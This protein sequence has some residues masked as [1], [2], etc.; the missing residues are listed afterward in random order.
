SFG[1]YDEIDDDGICFRT[2][3]GTH[4]TKGSFFTRGTSRDENA[5][6]TENG[7]LYAE[8]MR[9]LLKK[10]E[11]TKQYVPAPELYQDENNNEVGILFFGT[12]AQPSLEAMELLAEQGIL[13]DAMRITA[14]PFTAGVEAFIKAHQQLFV[15]EQ[16]RDAQMR[17]LL[18]AECG[19]APNVLASVL[20]FDGMPITANYITAQ[21]KQ[22]L[23]IS[24]VT[25]I[26][27]ETAQ[28][29]RI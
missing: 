23:S 21:I 27:S 3:P 4:P 16:N 8:N 13:V 6:Y 2:Y 5:V 18:M 25:P 20:N 22:Q 7:E 14:F 28:E 19:I 24:N 29:T 11:T 10:W 1:R 15:I 26:R 9:R 17:T 12:S